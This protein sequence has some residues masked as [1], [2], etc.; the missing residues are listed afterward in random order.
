[1]CNVFQLALKTFV[2]KGGISKKK[3]KEKKK[4]EEEDEKKKKVLFTKIGRKFK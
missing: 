4:E 1:M 2:S 3:K